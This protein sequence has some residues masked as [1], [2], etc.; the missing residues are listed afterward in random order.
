MSAYTDTEASVHDGQPIECFEFVGSYSTYRYTSHD[1]AVTVAGKKFDPIAIK[2][3][4]VKAGT[5][6]EDSLD[7]QVEMPVSC[8]LAKDYAFQVTPPKLELVIYRVH[9]G[10]NLA[11]DYVIYWRGPVAAISVENQIAKI[12]V[13]SVFANALSGDVP[14]VYYQSPCNHVLFDSGC[15]VNRALHS[16]KTTV[17]SVNGRTIVVASIGGFGHGYFNGGEIVVPGSNERRMVINQLGTTIEISYPMGMLA[18]GAEVELAAGCDHAWGGDCPN[19]FAN[20]INF[21]GF[22]FVPDINPFE[23]G[24]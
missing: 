3:T 20:Q 1:Q 24:F 7:V 8:Q 14:T 6:E 4:N 16:V 21:S 18:V 13:P 5:H 22:P 23:S 15:Q 2:R 11:T 12:R 9:L 17:L 10:T 19:K